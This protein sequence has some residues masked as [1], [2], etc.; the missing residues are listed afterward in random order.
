[1]P[2]LQKE[3]EI[4]GRKLLYNPWKKIFI[5]TG[6]NRRKQGGEVVKERTER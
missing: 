2:D 4:G 6:E 3:V 1:M 5:E